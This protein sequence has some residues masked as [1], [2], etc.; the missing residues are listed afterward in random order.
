M[1]VRTSAPVWEELLRITQTIPESDLHKLPT[2]MSVNHDHY[3]Y[4]SH[5]E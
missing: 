3:L 5:T 4:G 1:K 2:D